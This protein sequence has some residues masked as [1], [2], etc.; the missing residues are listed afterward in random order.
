MGWLL[1]VRTG[2]L[3]PAN[4]VHLAQVR[5]DSAR[6]GDPV[7][8][9]RKQRRRAESPIAHDAPIAAAI[10]APPTSARRA[11]VHI[12]VATVHF[13]ANASRPAWTRAPMA[14]AATWR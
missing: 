13:M 14:R 7:A 5:R 6:I 1:V 4:Q 9:R 3:Q 8:D 12:E 2:R 11:G 10:A